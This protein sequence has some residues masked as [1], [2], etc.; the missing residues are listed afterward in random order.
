MSGLVEGTNIMF[1]IEKKE[2]PV[3]RWRDVIYGRLFVDYR[4][5]KSDPYRTRLT[6]VGYRVN[7]M[8]YC[9]TPTVVLNT[10]KLLLNSIVLTLNA[11]HDKRYQGFLLEHSHGKEQLHAPQTKQPTQDH[12]AK[13]QSI[14]EGNQ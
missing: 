2:V 7:Y 14:S 12:G 3:D 10:A 13:I 6:V 8:G 9:G 5:E 11:I 1:F 4:T